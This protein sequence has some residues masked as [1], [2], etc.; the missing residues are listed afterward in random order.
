[1]PDTTWLEDHV[2]LYVTGA[3]PDDELERFERELS[4]LSPLEHTLIQSRIDE[5]GDTLAEFIGTFA[6]A[7]PAELRRL[8]LDGTFGAEPSA[9]APVTPPTSIETARARRR[10]APALAAAAAAVVV[11]LGA[12][13]VIGRTTAPDD[14]GPSVSSAQQS[15]LSVLDAP[16]AT[17][18]TAALSG[19]IGR[20]SVVSSRSQNRAVA[21]LAD[22]T[23]PLPADR[24]YQLWLM[25]KDGSETP[26]SAGVILPEL[27]GDPA[28]IAGLDGS[29]AVA[30]TVEPR[31]GSE[32]PTT[33]VLAVVTL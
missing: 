29:T 23:A 15:L 13:V 11:A 19:D 27:T 1:M 16:D 9:R 32:Q 12:G 22:L 31:A 6:A 7:P 17:I 10:W 28:D 30:I 5:A 8:V 3:M 25:E 20:I 4:L 21:V 26:V 14:T 2:E 18:G 24:S 33:P